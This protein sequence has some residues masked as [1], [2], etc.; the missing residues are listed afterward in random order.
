MRYLKKLAASL[1]LAVA[2]VASYNAL[3]GSDYGDFADGVPQ[4]A[5]TLIVAGG[6]FWCIEKDFETLDSVYEVVSGYAGGAKQDPTYRSHAGHREVVQIYYDGDAVSFD[7]LIDHYYRHVDYQDNGGQFCDRGYA[8]SPA[9][10]VKTQAERL[11]AEKLAPETSVV[12]I[13]DDVRFWPAEQYHQD[14]YMK[15]PVRYK[16]Y[17][18]SC[19]R[20]RRVRQLN[21]GS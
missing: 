17:R 2:A 15:N 20:D 14:Y 18:T 13:E 5:Q 1:T 16:F 9:I 8:Y 21:G 4:T 19:G 11:I 10:H 7:E 12:P 3:A 6:C